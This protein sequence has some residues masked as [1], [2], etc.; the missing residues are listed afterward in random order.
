MKS[1]E[2]FDCISKATSI[3]NSWGERNSSASSGVSLIASSRTSWQILSKSDLI[4]LMV[5]LRNGP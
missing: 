3:A 1:Q 4:M 2:L 5:S